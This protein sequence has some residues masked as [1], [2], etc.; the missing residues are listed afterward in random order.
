MRLALL[1]PLLLAAPAAA[2]DLRIVPG[3]GLAWFARDPGGVRR[4]ATGVAL[5]L[6][7]E[8]RTSR[9]IG[10]DVTLGW[11]LTDWDRAKE[12]IDAGDQAASWTTDKFGD[13]AAWV[14]AGEDDGTLLFRLFGA[15]FADAFLLMTYAAVPFC[16]VGS[17]GGATSHLQLDFTGSVHLDT[18]GP[19]DAWLEI[20]GGALLLPESGEGVRGGVGPLAGVGARFGRLRVGARV[21][22]SPPALN[23][24]TG[25]GSV[26]TGAVTLGLGAPPP[27][28][29]AAP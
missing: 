29:F 2:Q 12:W 7:L 18:A 6:R 22:W 17:V 21:L 15:F 14:R 19:G 9:R 24:A 10:F 25:G 26:L 16:Y 27:A 28:S 20:G 8:G 13:V 23:G 5:E 4:E 1:L 3:A 11:G